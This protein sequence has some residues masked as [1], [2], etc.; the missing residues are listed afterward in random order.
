MLLR[1]VFLQLNTTRLL[2]NIVSHFLFWPAVYAV[3]KHYGARRVGAKCGRTGRLRLICLTLKGSL[4]C[5][6]FALSYVAADHLPKWVAA[7]SA[8]TMHVG[9]VEITPPGTN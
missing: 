4:V 1:E 3:H 6:L 9:G 2:S 7:N 5:V 8:W